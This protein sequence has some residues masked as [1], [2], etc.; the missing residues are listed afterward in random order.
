MKTEL[1]YYKEFCI[2]CPGCSERDYLRVLSLEKEEQLGRMKLARRASQKLAGQHQFALETAAG[3]ISEWFL[4]A[5]TGASQ[6]P[7]T[8]EALAGWV[9]DLRIGRVWASLLGAGTLDAVQRGATFKNKE[10]KV[11]MH[12]P[13]VFQAKS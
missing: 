4:D 7:P 2:L 6:V 10:G 8:Y 12:F 5:N 3:R 9:L 11:L 13:P 1:D